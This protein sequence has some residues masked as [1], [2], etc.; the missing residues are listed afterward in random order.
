MEGRD[1]NGRDRNQKHRESSQMGGRESETI[2][3]NRARPT[4]S[5]LQRLVPQSFAPVEAH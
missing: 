3:Q 4:H 5:P 1:D 2:G